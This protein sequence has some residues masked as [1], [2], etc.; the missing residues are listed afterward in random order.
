MCVWL[1]D[2]FTVELWYA[3]ALRLL[4]CLFLIWNS[5]EQVCGSLQYIWSDIII[6]TFS[7]VLSIWIKL[8]S[9]SSYT[10]SLKLFP[11]NPL[12]KDSPGFVLIPLWGHCRWAVVSTQGHHEPSAKPLLTSG[13]GLP[14]WDL[15]LL[16]LS[17][18]LQLTS[19]TLTQ[20][21]YLRELME[22][23]KGKVNPPS[24]WPRVWV[25]GPRRGEA[26]WSRTT[27]CPPGS[28][29]ALKSFYLQKAWL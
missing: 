27:A 4:I 16:P 13:A 8:F 7:L 6:Y 15:C 29:T 3:K 25:A 26:G 24:A 9:L 23:W 18:T 11:I 14:H 1:S 22:I 28:E 12:R 17:F 2:L 5:H 21:S 19:Q 20:H 10:L